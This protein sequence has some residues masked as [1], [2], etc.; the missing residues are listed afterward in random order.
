MYI[1][2]V[3]K[4][5]TERYFLPSLQYNTSTSKPEFK[6][7]FTADDTFDYETRLKRNLDSR[8]L[9]QKIFGLGKQQA[10][11]KT[12]ME[13]ILFNMNQDK[14]SKAKNQEEW[15]KIAGY[16]K[17]KDRLEDIFISKLNLEKIGYN[18]N[19]PNGILLYGQHGTGKTK[20]AKAFAQKTDCEFVSIDTIQDDDD[21]IRDLKK[22]FKNAKKRYNSKE[23]PQK[24]TIILLD[25][26]N[27]STLLSEK[28]KKELKIGIIDFKETKAGQFANLLE[29]CANKYK[30]TVIMTSSQPRQF[31][32]GLFNVNLIPYQIFLGPPNRQDAAQIFKYHTKEYTNEDIDYNKLG[33]E[34]TKAIDNDEAYSAQGIINIIENAKV[35]TQNSDITEKDL[36]DSIKET[37]PDITQ[38]EF[39]DFV[40]DMNEILEEYETE[41][42]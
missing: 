3:R 31:D 32:T 28:D 6:I 42:N 2:P 1:Q 40:D 27:F 23:T 11:E 8:N 21:I 5:S 22:E 24:R 26:F 29:D 4:V 9:L 33:N 20:F 17:I 25:D 19:I 41:K 38:L 34:I 7:H 10:K 14:F 16:E 18:A 39:K 12:N 36:M 15:N 13:M 35:K 30:A 37:K